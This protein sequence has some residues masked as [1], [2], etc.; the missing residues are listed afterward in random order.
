MPFLNVFKVFF[1][2]TTDLVNT[3]V[4]F[5]EEIVAEFCARGAE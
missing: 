3:Q 1:F 4:N 2:D 5:Q